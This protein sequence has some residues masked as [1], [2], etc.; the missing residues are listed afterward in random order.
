M[1]NEEPIE[2]SF[3]INSPEVLQQAL[4]VEKG[5][6]GVDYALEKSE[7]NFQAYIDT[8][9]QVNQALNENVRLTQ[10]Q[11]RAY[12]TY[13]NTLEGLKKMMDSTT[14]PTQLAVYQF[15]I[16]EVSDSLQKLIDNANNKKLDVF[17]T[18]KLEQAG[19]LL[20]S[21]SD[22]TFSPSFASSQELEVLSEA[23][24]KAENEFQ[25][26]GIV[27]DFVGARLNKI[28]DKETFSSLRNDL[29]AANNILGRNIEL[30]DSAGNSIN[31]MK[32]ALLMFQEKLSSETDPEKITI[33]NKNIEDL[34]NNIRRVGNIG[35]TGFD[36]VGN[37][38]KAQEEQVKGLKGQL[39]ELVQE[40][41]KMRL[42]G[43]QNTQQYRELSNQAKEL[44][45][46]LSTVNEEVR[47][48]ASATNNLDTLIRA[49]KGIASGYAL[50]KS[51]GAL[52]GQDQKDVEQAILK[53]TSAMSLLQ[54]LQTIQAELLRKDSVAT[55][56]LTT[57]KGLYTK[58]I[59]D[60]TGA[61]KGFKI[62]LFSVGIGVAIVLLSELVANWDKVKK[63]IGLTSD[64]LERNQTISKKGNELYGEKI[65][66]LQLLSTTNEKVALTENQKRKA[67]IDYNKEFGNVLG[68]VKDYAQL[69]Q[70]VI[71]NLPNYISYLTVKSQA[72]ASYMLSLEKQKNLLEQITALSTGD[73]GW[74]ESLQNNLDKFGEKF[75]SSL[76]LKE[77]VANR[78]ISQAEILSFLNIPS[79]EDF[80]QAITG[81]SFTI[82]E[83]LREFR[84]EQAKDKTMLEASFELQKKAGEL[85][86]KLKIKPD[87]KE[88]DAQT[89][90][91]LADKIKVLADI[92][93]A[94]GDLDKSR[95]TGL[96]KDLKD[97][98]LRYTKLRDEAKKA[99]L[100]LK[101]IERIDKLET[102]E[103]NSVQYN[104]DTDKLQKQLEESKR[105]YEEYEEFKKNS[106]I[107]FANETFGNL[108]N[109]TKTYYDLVSDELDKI[110][111]SDMTAEEKK[112]YA[113]LTELLIQHGED[114]SKIEHKQLEEMY[115]LTATTEQKLFQLRDK[116]AKLNLELQSKYTG[117][118]LENRS[119][120][121]A[122]QAQDEFDALA[123]SVL[124]S[125]GT[126][127]NALDIISS[128]TKGQLKRQIRDLTE[129]LNTNKEISAE[130]R[131]IINDIIRDLTNRLPNAQIDR[132]D[133]MT[134][135]GVVDAQIDMVKK[136]IEDLKAQRQT[137][138]QDNDTSYEEFMN[139]SRKMSVS[140]ELLEM[141]L[142][143]LNID[144]ISAV[145]QDLGFIGDQ[146]LSV[147]NS[148]AEINPGMSDLFKIIGDGLRV[149]EA[150]TKVISSLGSSLKEAGKIGGGT[151][152]GAVGAIMEGV[153][154]I[155]QVWSGIVQ[156]QKQAYREFKQWQMDVYRGELEYQALL[157]KRRYDSISN[158]TTNKTML[159][160]QLDELKKQTPEIEREIE[161]QLQ[162]IQNKG[163]Y[164]VDRWRSTSFWRTKTKTEWGDLFGVDYDK[165]EELY[166]HN[167]L[168]GDTKVWFEELQKLKEELGDVQ[169]VIEETEQALLDAIT[170]TTSDSL[171]DSIRNGLAEGKRSFED[172]ADDIEGILKNAIMQGMITDTLNEGVKDLQRELADLMS[173]GELSSTDADK[174]RE[175]YMQLVEE[176]QKKMDALNQAGIDFS[177]GD[178]KNSLKGAIK[179]MTETQ[180]DL[181]SGQIGGWRLAQLETNSILKNSFTSQLE[182]LSRQVAIQMQIEIN[183]RQTS[184]NTAKSNELLQSL[185]DRSR[186]LRNDS[187][188]LN[189]NGWTP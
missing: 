12:D 134:A 90:K 56:A 39:A 133:T 91:A 76:G 128:A 95:L 124:Q 17:D 74:Y 131:K 27:I 24:N 59:G 23:I 19:H 112:R 25:Q 37:S 6:Q 115:N 82:K 97:I 77:Q 118:E 185:L 34:E 169:K 106:S 113:M 138:K 62:A 81:F 132:R 160:S 158:K 58:A 179:G 175:M 98:E 31:Q 102:Q 117:K 152:L 107:S 2:I 173:D 103:I 183:T 22:K 187:T 3:I 186:S 54:G 189:A 79:D 161:K 70:Q 110:N 163:E 166:K 139:K 100:E 137:L 178:D 46:A 86:S 96:A 45:G 170:G 155:A 180:A 30:Y 61:L 176:A 123:D 11:K 1:N 136:Q 92:K 171:I 29:D 135:T 168:E 53:V 9:L 42:N 36:E 4:A 88:A 144:K 84:K 177:N 10:A 71:K 111:V 162:M 80:N 140:I 153:G 35:R 28:N 18:D 114:K 60:S 108:I 119:K 93:K 165:L 181:L 78:E 116:Y 69:E 67:V 94:E 57:L 41:A 21:I 148:L 68:S 172:F 38:I 149:M 55:K 49:T 51:A 127:V 122:K 52:F 129:F 73:L 141:R 105:I 121:L 154:V 64:E 150:V 65:A 142:N 147:S 48:S 151:E 72:E 66:K 63:A 99:K 126:Y 125:S 109:V 44:A 120:V 7:K 50:A 26:L 87:D 20:D 47:H 33:L 164:I 156:A 101:D 104:N 167:K 32:D 85:A 145:G 89:K 13:S 182:V 16:Q 184:T 8:Q 15:K 40:L 5:L 14:D 43:Q 146:F 130:Q 75:R 159:S 83:K 157:R 143:S 174:I 188:I